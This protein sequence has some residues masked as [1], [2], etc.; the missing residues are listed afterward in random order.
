MAEA[1]RIKHIIQ[2]IIFI[3]LTSLALWKIVS[4]V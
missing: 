4:E 3:L 2:M 1:L